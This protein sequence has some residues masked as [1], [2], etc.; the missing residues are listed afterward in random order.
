MF[1]NEHLY[2]DISVK[3]DKFLSNNLENIEI[4]SSAGI[5]SNDINLATLGVTREQFCVQVH[6]F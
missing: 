1:M 4:L 2:F 6:T 5:F 3:F